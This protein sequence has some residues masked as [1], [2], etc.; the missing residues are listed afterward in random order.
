MGRGTNHPTSEDKLFSKKSGKRK[1]NKATK[2]YDPNLCRVPSK[3][4]LSDDKHA[5]FQTINM[6]PF[7]SKAV[8]LLRLLLPI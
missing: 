2:E 6:P 3:I 1:K 7:R 8:S 5:P 4:K